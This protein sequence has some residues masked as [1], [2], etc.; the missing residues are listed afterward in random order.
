V[1]LLISEHIYGGKFVWH[2]LFSL[3]RIALCMS[4]FCGLQKLF[5]FFFLPCK[6][7]F[8]LSSTLL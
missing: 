2:L 6:I 8:S 5:L 4:V 3:V 7:S 1:I